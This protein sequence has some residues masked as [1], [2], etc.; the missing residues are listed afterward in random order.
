M[1]NN[2]ETYMAPYMEKVI[3]ILW[4]IDSPRMLIHY[5]EMSALGGREWRR[6]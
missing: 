2:F 4:D 6:G 1:R 5:Y 3:K